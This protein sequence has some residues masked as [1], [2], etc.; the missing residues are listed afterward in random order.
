MM[1]MNRQRSGPSSS[2]RERAEVF[3]YQELA[4]A[5]G[6]FSPETKIGSGSFGTVY[7]GKLADGREVAIKRSESGPKTQK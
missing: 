1:K 3:S 6:N 5:T 7:K 4:E 2:M